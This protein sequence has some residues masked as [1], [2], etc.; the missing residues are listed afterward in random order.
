ML[1]WAKS[2]WKIKYPMRSFCDCIRTELI[3]LRNKITPQI[4]AVF[5]II[6][7]AF[8]LKRLTMG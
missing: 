2:I 4:P 8:E 6:F 5:L 7:A 3:D 1:F